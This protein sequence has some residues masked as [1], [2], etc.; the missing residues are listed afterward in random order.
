MTCFNT[1]SN[2]LQLSRTSAYN[3]HSIEHDAKKN[4]DI[5]PYTLY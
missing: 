1:F 3:V 2:M 4:L 5:S